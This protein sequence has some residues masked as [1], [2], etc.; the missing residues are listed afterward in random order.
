MDHDQR[1]KLGLDAA[2]C[3][4]QGN[5]EKNNRSREQPA[6]CPV[7]IQTEYRG[8]AG[9]GAAPASAVERGRCRAPVD[10]ETMVW[11]NL[12]AALYL[13]PRPDRAEHRRAFRTLLQFTPVASRQIEPLLGPFTG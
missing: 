1:I 3:R 5:D 9:G 13:Q 10:S 6:A 4:D 7:R 8:P 2:L 11:R 12:V